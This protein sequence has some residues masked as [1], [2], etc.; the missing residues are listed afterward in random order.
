MSNTEPGGAAARDV[1]WPIAFM[2]GVLVL[3]SVA[4]AILLPDGRDVGAIVTP[5][6]GTFTT[7]ALMIGG[8]VTLQR[9]VKGV[10]S[11]VDQVVDV[12]NATQAD[13]AEIR[14]QTNGK[15]DHRIREIGYESMRRALA[16]HL[17][18][19]EQPDAFPS[20]RARGNP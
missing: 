7:L 1:I 4:L 6:V 14:E 16:D 3:G 15:L 17:D 13:T 11:K 20:A 12:A 18:P 10:D 2:F 8:W 5:L 19:D 9:M